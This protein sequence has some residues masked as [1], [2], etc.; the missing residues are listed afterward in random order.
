[1][2]LFVVAL[3]ILAATLGFLVGGSHSPV[4]GVA[5]T[6][7]F[8]LV[9]TATGLLA[10]TPR[11]PT[12]SAASPAPAGA[13]QAVTERTYRRTGAVL[14]VF[15]VLFV[16][17]LSGGISVRTSS[18][19]Q[20]RTFPWNDANKPANAFDAVDWLVVQE[21]LLSRGYTEQQVQELYRGWSPAPTATSFGIARPL[22]DLFRGAPTG[23]GG[24][25][26]IAENRP[27]A[28]RMRLEDFFERTS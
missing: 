28:G 6:A 21:N 18:S 19:R 23:E 15:A 8:G 10:T 2:Y 1:M 11:A 13:V 12:A 14:L 16:A 5:I 27:P 24:E 22:S 26:F 4:A 9:V 20:A 7:V 3:G 25:H 17:G